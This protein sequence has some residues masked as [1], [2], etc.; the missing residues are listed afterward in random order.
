M[1]FRDTFSLAYRTVRGNKLRTGLTV[2]IIAFGI[3]ALVGIRTAIAAME[4][5][6][7]ESF[8]S[9]GATGFTVRYKEPRFRFGGQELKKEKKGEKKEKKSNIGKPITRQQ[10]EAFKANFNFPAQV[11]L[12]MFGSNDAV[13]SVGGK[14]SNPTTRVY[15]GDENWVDQNGFSIAYGRNLNTLDIQTARNVCLIGTDVAKKFFGDDLERPID[16]II[17]VNNIP[18]RVVGT[19]NPKGSTL[20]MT[21]DNAIIT[22]YNNVRRFFNSN[23]NASFNIQVKVSDIKLMDAAT[24]QATATFRPIRKLTT[25]EDDNFAIDKSDSFA[26]MLIGL[27]SSLTGAAL[28]IGFITLLGAAIGLTNIMLVA[29]TERTKEIGLAKAI[30]GKQANIKWQFLFESTIISLFGAFFGIILGVV[31]GNLFSMYLNTGFVIP[32][33]WTITGIIICTLV[34]LLAGLYPA[35]KA[36][37]LNPIEALRYE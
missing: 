9:M 6:F 32:W 3:M 36:S 24:G 33:F 17:K 34:G 31:V 26:E 13:V 35:Q 11:S 7:V 23:P 8:S 28:I 18:F 22:S 19:L 12:T 16:Q 14:K 15:G 20:G 2:A 1:K 29:V 10:A 25:T 4:Q 27:L 30:G 37:R 5:K 21:W